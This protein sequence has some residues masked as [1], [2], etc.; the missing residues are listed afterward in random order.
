MT[1]QQVFDDA[2]QT[3]QQTLP[4]NA[5]DD[6]AFDLSC[7]FSHC[8]GLDRYT[9]VLHGT[10]E[11]SQDETRIFY[12]LFAR[13]LAAQPLQ[14]LLGEWEFYGLPF[15][16]GPGV[17]IPRADTE[18]LVETGLSL[19]EGISSPVIADLCAGS[20]CICCALTHQFSG[21]HA[22][23]FELSDDALGYLRENVRRH[24]LLVEVV[25]CDVLSPPAELPLF[26]LIVSNPPYLSAQ[27]I[28]S[29]QPQVTYEP[30]MAL[31]GGADGYDFY[32]ALPLLWKE[33]LKPGGWLAFEVGY[34]QAETVANLLRDAGYAEIFTR[35]DLGGVTRVV[36]A[37]RPLF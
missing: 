22:Y 37:R 14:Y 20:G 33:K 19:L 12:D 36:A 34:T 8:F 1:L 24:C 13:Y 7:L 29:L 23:A 11:V 16:V 4:T 28:D 30:Q 9:L 5:Q 2:L 6:C 15:Q 27:E 10:K 21:A 25:A 17:L 3:M 32:R 35:Q 18:T 31:L 26:D